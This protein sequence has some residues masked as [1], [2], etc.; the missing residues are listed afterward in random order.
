MK[1]LNCVLSKKFLYT[2]DSIKNAKNSDDLNFYVGVACGIASGL[3]L[4]G[5][6]DI[7][8]YT[9]MHLHI[10]VVRDECKL[11]RVIDDER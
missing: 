8:C 7:D 5:V 4:S 3:W 10:C 9:A 11:G 6:I 1:D 2:C